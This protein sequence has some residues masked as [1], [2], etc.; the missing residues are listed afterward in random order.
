MDIVTCNEY[1]N[2]V[3]V[4]LGNGD[5]TFQNAVSYGVGFRPADVALA[6][7][8]GKV[9]I[10][11]S[12]V[13]DRTISVLAGNG[14]GTFQSAV[15]YPVAPVPVPVVAADVNGDGKPDIVTASYTTNKV[16][17]LLGQADGT[18][19]NVWSVGNI[20]SLHL[21]AVQDSFLPLT[22]ALGSLTAA[23]WQGGGIQAATLG[24]L[25]VTGMWSADLTLNAGSS[26]K[27]ALGSATL[28]SIA[29]STWNIIGALGRGNP[30]PDR[31]PG[32]W[33]LRPTSMGP[34]PRLVVTGQVQSST[35]S[36]QGRI[37]A[38]QAAQWDSTNLTAQSLGLLSITGNTASGEA[39]T[40]TNSAVTLTGAYSGMGLGGVRI[41]GMVQYSTFNVMAG[42]V[43]SFTCARFISSNLYVGYTPAAGGGFDSLGTFLGPYKLQL[44]TTTSLPPGPQ[45]SN[46]RT[47]GFQDSEIVAN[48]FGQ[49]MLSGVTINNPSTFGLRVNGAANA[50]TVMIG[51][52]PFR[53]G[54]PVKPGTVQQA[55]EFVDS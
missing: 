3:S 9:A 25:N 17:V 31:S 48:R 7:I 5:A 4:L 20:Q 37:S 23:S 21:G 28:G 30:G 41:A 1:S 42:N 51:T 38:I 19:Q 39:G 44:F 47:D 16:N 43:G 34:G 8:N 12:N 11:T 54:V 33:L 40:F 6:N 13:N 15:A 32:S 46:P 24:T 10:V 36:V 52:L 53:P 2:T 49:V 14:D 18:F 29:N 26:I 27:Q 35:I 55:F 22:G 50:G 45:Q